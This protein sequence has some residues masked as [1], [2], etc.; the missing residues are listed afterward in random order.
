M[1]GQPLDKSKDSLSVG[2]EHEGLGTTKRSVLSQLAKIY[3]PLGLVSPMTLQ[4]KNHFRGICEARLPWDGELPE[5]TT[6]RW[7]DWRAG[8]PPSYEIPPSLAPYQV[9]VS[10]I[11]LH[12]FGDASK[13]GVSAVVNAVVEQEQEMTQGLVCSKSWLAKRTLSIPRLELVAE[14]WR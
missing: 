1:L 13:V 3:D 6:R 12:A 10:A 11:T 8:F 14:T 9:Y 4:G 7:E 2:L 5:T